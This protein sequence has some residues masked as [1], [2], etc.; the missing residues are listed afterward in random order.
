MK[1]QMSSYYTSFCVC[2]S[3]EEVLAVFPAFF[4]FPWTRLTPL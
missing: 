3:N 1:Y 2:L 4:V